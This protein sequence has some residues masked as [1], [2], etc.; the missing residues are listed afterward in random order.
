MTESHP[1][2]N[3][4]ECPI[5]F[6]TKLHRILWTTTA[7]EG[8][9]LARENNCD[10]IIGIGGGSIMDCAK[11]IAFLAVNKGD[12][13]DYIYNRQKSENA[14]PLLLIPTTCGTGSEGNGFAVLTNPKTEIKNLSAAM[15]SYR[16]SPL[17]IRNV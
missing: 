4:P 3:S 7:E 17:Q 9:S 14:L 15:R 13:N 12:I 10:V 8:A 16:K 1:V 5:C 11:A 6:L 2:W